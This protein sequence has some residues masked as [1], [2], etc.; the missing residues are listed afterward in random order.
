MHPPMTLHSGKKLKVT[1]GS[2]NSVVDRPMTSDERR[3]FNLAH[4]HHAWGEYGGLTTVTR[5]N[6]A[7]QHKVCA[8]FFHASAPTNTHAHTQQ[9]QKHVNPRHRDNNLQINHVHTQHRLPLQKRGAHT[10]NKCRNTNHTHNAQMM[11]TQTCTRAHAKMRAHAACALTKSSSFHHAISPHTHLF[12]ARTHQKNIHTVS[13][14][15]PC[16]H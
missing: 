7:L 11:N 13:N 8:S 5:E 2:R 12:F 16:N 6:L 4:A 10:Q 14:G 3:L 9:Q 15:P 1:V